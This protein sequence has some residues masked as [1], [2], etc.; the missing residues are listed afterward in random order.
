M[1][2][3]FMRAALILTL[4]TSTAI[5][6]GQS[7]SVRIAGPRV[8]TLSA[9]DVAAL[10]R[11]TVKVSVQNQEVTYEGVAIRELLTRAG[12]PA[13]QAMHGPDLSSAVVVTGADGYRVAFGTAEFDP[14][15]T[16]RIG[17]LADRKNGA[18]LAG[19]EAPFML[20]L[21]GEKHPSRWVRQV[22]A[23]DVQ[24]VGR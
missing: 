14:V 11:V 9:A 23:I 8:L 16:D 22:V 24:P 1:K 21:T 18:P 17:I 5:V 2:E 6:A 10:P 15:F 20:I 4:I 7:A 3:G 13:G 19:N 12:V